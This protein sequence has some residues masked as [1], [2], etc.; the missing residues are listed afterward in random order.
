MANLITLEEYKAA[1]NMTKPD[2]DEVLQILITN[3]SA[4]IQA[5]IGRNL[6]NS[7]EP[8]EEYINLDYDTRNIY[9]DQYPVN[10]II[11]IDVYDNRP[12]YDSTV[13]FPIYPSSYILSPKEG[14]LM[15]TGGGPGDCYWPQAPIKVVY[16]AGAIDD[17]GIPPELKQATIDLVTY[18]HKEEYKD[19]KSIRGATTNNNTGSGNSNSPSTNFPPHIQRVLD[20][21]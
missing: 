9:L 2:M 20:L 19:S 14:M 1:K 8:I 3:T 18:Y 10:E 5:Y 4:I 15:R 13:H 17:K 11:S 21:F 7:G 16:T 6:F 12:L